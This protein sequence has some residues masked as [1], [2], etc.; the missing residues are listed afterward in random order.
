MK[1]VILVDDEPACLR[2]MSREC[3]KELEVV[4]A[5]S[6]AE[7]LRALADGA[8]VVLADERIDGACDG[9]DL[10]ELVRER[11]P[12]CHR[13]LISAAYLATDH[14][15]ARGLESGLIERF[16]AKPWGDQEIVAALGELLRTGAG[17]ARPRPLVVPAPPSRA[18]QGGAA[19][20]PIERR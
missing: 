14:R 2:A 8:D 20:D 16:F 17:A 19:R 9:M 13:A 7:A 10:L 15:V 5:R 12:G 18:A 6:A 4:P 11:A 1:R 3:R